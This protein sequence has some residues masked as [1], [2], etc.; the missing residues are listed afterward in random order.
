MSLLAYI[1][2]DRSRY[3]GSGSF[4]KVYRGSYRDAPCAVKMI[5]TLDLTTE[6]IKRVAA[7]A[8]ILSQI[9]VCTNNKYVNETRISISYNAAHI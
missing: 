1:T 2:L 7:E 6:V 4:S 5:F 9:Q 3:L 8:H